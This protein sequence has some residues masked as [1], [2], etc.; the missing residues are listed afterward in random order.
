M[1]HA[2]VTVYSPHGAGE[3]GISVWKS[4]LGSLYGNRDMI[5]YLAKRDILARYRQSIMGYLWIILLPV[6][7]VA[8]VGFLAGRRIL[9]VGETPLPYLLFA[10]CNLT[11]WMLFAGILA[12]TTNSLKGA[13]PL[14]TR[15]NCARDAIV[16]AAIAQP[17]VDFIVRL[18][19]VASVFIWFGIS[20][21]WHALYAALLLLPLIVMAV[22]LGF[23]L[24][25][26]NLVINDVGY[27]LGIILTFAVFLAPILYPPPVEWPFYLVNILNPVSPFLIGMQDL[28]AHGRVSQPQSLAAASLFAVFVFLCGWRLFNLAIPRVVQRA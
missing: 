25:I 20:P 6:G 13:G 21:P 18:L 1:Q 14:V 26:L 28:I 24:S 16:I 3:H 4:M 7:T 17:L 23:F 27:A 9:L 8:I 12:A 19:V 22:G 11:V 15:I 5:V 2:P 10:L